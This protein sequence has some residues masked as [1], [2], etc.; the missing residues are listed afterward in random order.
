MQIVVLAGFVVVLTLLEVPLEPR[1][2]LIVP[3]LAVYLAV[4]ALMV[5]INTVVSLRHFRRRGGVSGVV[6]RRHN[7]LAILTRCWLVGG[8]AAATVLGYGHWVKYGTYLGTIPLI[9]K[10]AV[11]APFFAALILAARLSVSPGGAAARQRCRAVGRRQRRGRVVAARVPEL[12]RATSSAVH[13]R[14][15]LAD[16][17]GA[18]RSTDVRLSA[19]R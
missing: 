11:L 1:P 16:R 5:G 9:G 13:R 10:L 12:Q 7:R 3:S 17:P 6:L 2:G 4:T 15:D 18:R 19:V 8:I 14:A